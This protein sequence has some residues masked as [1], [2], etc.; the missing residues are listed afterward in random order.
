MSVENITMSIDQ[1]ALYLADKQCISNKYKGINY[2]HAITILNNIVLFQ[3][4]ESLYSRMR[5][6]SPA[7]LHSLVK[8]KHL[9]QAPF[10]S[11]RLAFVSKEQLQ[12]F[13]YS[14]LRDDIEYKRPETRAVLEFIME[15]GTSTR[16]RIIDQFKLSKEEVMDILAELRSYYQIFMFYDGTNWTLFS[17]DM[18][19]DSESISKST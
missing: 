15:K 16:Q 7:L 11:E 10:K 6:Y 2:A 5:T 19:L 4:P 17:S 18:L 13:Y 8:N 9:V 12:N 3:D 14:N 1:L